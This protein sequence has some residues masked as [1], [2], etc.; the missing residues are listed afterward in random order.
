LKSQCDVF[1]DLKLQEAVNTAREVRRVWLE[2]TEM[3]SVTD[4]F[5]SGYFFVLRVFL[6]FITKGC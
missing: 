2:A 6:A 1:S 3:D 4:T 5:V